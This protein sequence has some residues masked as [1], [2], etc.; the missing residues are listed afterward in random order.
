MTLPAG[1]AVHRR[2]RHEQVVERLQLVPGRIPQPDPGQHGSADLHRP[3]DRPRLP[4]GLPRAPRLQRAAREEPGEGSRLDRVHGLSAV[5]AAV[6]DRRGHGQFRH[7]GGVPRAG[8]RG[9]RADHA[10]PAGRPRSRRGR[11]STTRCRRSSIS[12]RTRATRRRAGIS[13]GE[14]DAAQAAAWLERYALMPH[15]RAAQRVR[16][17]DQY[18]KL[19]DQLQPREGHGAPLHRVAWRHRRTIRRSDGTEFE[20]LLSSPRLPSGLQ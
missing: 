17:F 14:I 7:R 10:V 13:N 19:R 6:A 16:F 9:V 18:R 2:V 12:W 15:D 1:R 3:R 20:K 11:R 4:R 5:L 8:A